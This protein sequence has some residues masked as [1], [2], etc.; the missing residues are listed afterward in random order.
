MSDDCQACLLLVTID[1][2]LFHVLSEAKRKI[3]EVCQSSFLLH[4]WFKVLISYLFF[5]SHLET[6]E[7]QLIRT[8]YGSI[9]GTTNIAVRF[10]D[11]EIKTFHLQK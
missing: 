11:T 2:E 5:L 6:E 10:W 7:K 9:E 3:V 8:N 1:R 4:V